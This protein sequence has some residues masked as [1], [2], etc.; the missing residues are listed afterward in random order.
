MEGSYVDNQIGRILSTS[1]MDP[2]LGRKLYSMPVFYTLG[3]PCLC[4]LSGL[5]F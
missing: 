2:Y 3:K 1:C 4:L 5:Q